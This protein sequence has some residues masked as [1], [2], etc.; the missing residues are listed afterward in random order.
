MISSLKIHDE[1]V[2]MLVWILSEPKAR[3]GDGTGL[4]KMQLHKKIKHF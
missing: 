2:R 1:L 4:N 3:A